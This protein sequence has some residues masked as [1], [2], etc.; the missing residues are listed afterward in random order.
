MA[1]FS[2]PVCLFK[3]PLSP[4]GYRFPPLAVIGFNACPY[5]VKEQVRIGAINPPMSG[6]TPANDPSWTH[7]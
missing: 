4:T 2:Q 6:S 5:Q 3:Q 7:L 1:L